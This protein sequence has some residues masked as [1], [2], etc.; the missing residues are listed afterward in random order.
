MTGRIVN[1]DINDSGSWRRVTSFDLDTFEDGD[2]EHCAHGLLELSSNQKLK[3]RLI[4]PGE[5]VPLMT[6]KHGDMWREWGEK[7][8]KL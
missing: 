1:L 4:A 7:P 6:W 8:W 5:T 2:L 3:A